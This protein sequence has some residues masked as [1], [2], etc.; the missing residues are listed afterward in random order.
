MDVR[1][2]R[3]HLTAQ[4]LIRG[5][6]VRIG[7]ESFD[8]DD[9]LRDLAIKDHKGWRRFVRAAERVAYLIVLLEDEEI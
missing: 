6:L 9:V 5:D 2:R 4:S 7:R 1:Q 8:I 3:I